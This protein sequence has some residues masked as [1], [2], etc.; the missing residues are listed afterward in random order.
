MAW[1]YLLLAGLSEVSWIVLLKANNGFTKMLPSL[2]ALLFILAGPYC[3]SL[4]MKTL[5]M[6]TSYAV[7]IGVNCVLMLILG[8]VFFDEPVSLAKLACIAL[9]VAGAVGLKLI[10]VG[11]IKA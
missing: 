10:E 1:V 4:A 2:A 9:I 5:G 8:A 6:G 11:V 3:V 7:W